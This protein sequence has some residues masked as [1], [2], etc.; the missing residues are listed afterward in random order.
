LNETL[1][2]GDNTSLR[3]ISG[4]DP[5]TVVQDLMG[6]GYQICRKNI[7]PPALSM[8]IRIV[9]RRNA[10]VWFLL[11]TPGQENRCRALVTAHRANDVTGQQIDR[12]ANG[13]IELQTQPPCVANQRSTDVRMTAVTADA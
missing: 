11:P 4:L 5:L 12:N 10:N 8:Q 13:K 7:V 1:R 9:A 6:Q 2:F 3:R